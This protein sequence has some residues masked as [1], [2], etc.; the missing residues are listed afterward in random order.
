MGC[1]AAVSIVTGSK[2]TAD[3]AYERARSIGE[4]YERRFS[5]FLDESELAT[6]N[7]DKSGAVSAEFMD[8]LMHAQA[9]YE[10]TR[11]VFNVLVQINALGYDRDF[12]TLDADT[13]RTLAVPAYDTD[14]ATV[15]VD[16][17]QRTVTLGPTQKFDFGGFLKGHAAEVMATSMEGVEGA[18]VN[19]GGDIFADGHDA[20]GGPFKFSVYNPVRDDYPLLFPVEHGAVATS[21]TYRRHWTV[22]GRTVHHILGPSGTENPLSDIV[23]ATVLHAHGYKA[24]AYATVAVALGSA[25]APTFLDERDITYVL[26]TRDGML[27]NNT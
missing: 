16:P 14:L 6:L 19:I 3:R 20:M 2:R 1:D 12:R 22:N 26:I 7:R 17:A 8:A 4:E 25:A 21:G 13:D 27:I 24:D 23:S 18:L 9:L 5:R 10:E 15:Q 11:G